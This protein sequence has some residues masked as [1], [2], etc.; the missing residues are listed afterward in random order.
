MLHSSS[1]E[2][3]VMFWVLDPWH[4]ERALLLP[5]VDIK[6]S[7][8]SWWPQISDSSKAQ[9]QLIQHQ[10]VFTCWQFW[11]WE[12]KIHMPSLPL[13][14][15]KS[16]GSLYSLLTQE[17]VGW[18]AATLRMPCSARIQ[19]SLCTL[20]HVSSPWAPWRGSESL[21]DVELMFHLYFT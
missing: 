6:G 11:A 8:A 1:V 14:L 20:P 21:K 17:P 3:R 10:P 18:V 13:S 15:G 5:Q 7:E 19:R 16:D 2:I 12:M 4:L 9:A